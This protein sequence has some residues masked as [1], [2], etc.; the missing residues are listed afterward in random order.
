MKHHNPDPQTDRDMLKESVGPRMPRFYRTPDLVDYFQGGPPPTPKSDVFQLGLVLAELFTGVNPQAPF[1]GDFAAPVRL[2][3]LG[4]VPGGMGRMI[5]SAIEPML[6][7]DREA[8]PSATD[9]LDRW[10]ELFL[11]A[12][13]RSHALEGRVL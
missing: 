11:E 2:N 7:F 8:R 6:N 5:K 12:A 3:P 1:E 4:Y 9:L 13:K 10:Q